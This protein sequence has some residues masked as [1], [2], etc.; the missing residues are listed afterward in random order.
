[1]SSLST[2][3]A[4]FLNLNNQN[5]KQ[6]NVVVDIDGLPLFGSLTIYRQILFGDPI[7]YGDSGLVY[8]GLIP[9]GTVAGERGQKTT[10]SMEGGAL[11]ISQRLEPEQGRG[12]ISTLSMTFVD[13]NGYMTQVV[14]P[15]IIVP[16]ILGRQV[17][18]W[19][20]YENSG[21]PQ[22]YFVVWRG[23]VG[24]V[25]ADVGRVTMQ[26]V[27]PNVVRRQQ[28]FYCGQSSLSTNIDNA[29]TTIPMVSNGNFFQKI[30]GPNGTYDGGVR[31]FIKVGDEFIEYQ[32]GGHE[33]DGYGTN[34]FLNVVRGVSPVANMATPSVAAAH[35]A[36]DTVDGYIMLTD[37][38]MNLALK[39]MLSGFNGPYKTGQS[40]LSLGPMGFS[41]AILLPNNV[42]AV[43]D[44]G[45]SVG[46][47]IT[48][49]GDTYGGNNVTCTVT[50]FNDQYNQTNRY[51]FTSQ[52]F[53]ESDSSPATISLR[54]QYDVYPM[55]AGCTLPAWEVDVGT[56]Q[57][58]KN[59]FLNSSFNSYQFLINGT[60]EAGKTFIESEILLPLGAYSLTRQGKISMG[61]TKPPIADARTQVLSNQNVLSP[62]SIQVQRGVNNRKFFNEIDWSYDC[63]ETN[64]PTSQRNAVN[65]TS[66]ATIGI[67]S[68]LPI[69]SRGARTSLGFTTIVSNRENLIFNRYANASVLI[70]L[71]T[72]LGVGNQ[73]EVGDVLVLNDNGALQIPNFSTGL[74]NLGTQLFEVIN[75]SLDFKTGV[76]TLQ[77]EGG[78]G[79]V[80]TDRFAT[81]APSS[82]IVNGSTGSRIIITE[83]F[84]AIYPG[85]EQKKWTSYVGLNVRVHSTDWL[86][87]GTTVFTG[88]DPNNNHA[89][90]L[91]PA[92][93]FTPTD[94]MIVDLAQYP[95]NSLKTDQAVAKL[96]HAY[97]DPTVQVVSGASQTVFN[98]G[99]GDISKFQIGQI[100]FLHDNT[101]TR[102][103]SEVTITNIS[104]NTITV[105]TALGFTPDASMKIELIGFADGGYAYRMV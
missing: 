46:D 55:L 95:T 105:N 66:L 99:G 88:F 22:D 29:T 21:W 69:T 15:G 47:Y 100:I 79:A 58:Y 62:E 85:N 60:G 80:P 81:I 68:I 13:L 50:G 86:V 67:S 1:M 2:P 14:S 87:S 51:I 63:D 102:V 31:L 6:I 53:T 91:S 64:T 23:R 11:T 4:N 52:T 17:K 3:T 75:R 98:V 20:G 94:G 12:S 74:R 84:G 97:M 48:I 49:S 5:S 38:A 35:N 83:S 92:L 7:K 41:T 78:T 73:I 70:D 96:V 65:A 19:F 30:T 71:K 101:Y 103:S 44:L 54:S 93:S 42:D 61:L 59:T 40:I 33:T 76:A 90:L 25:M 82:F 39:I 37:H 28:I 77:L 16:E 24:Q 27:D 18:I 89:M 45:L 72:T 57:Y 26:F 36:G 34:Q 104:G 43:R 8:G 10:L 9:V 32:Q 56:F